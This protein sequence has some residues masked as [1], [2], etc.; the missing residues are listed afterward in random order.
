MGRTGRL[1]CTLLKR[2]VAVRR[3]GVFTSKA[4]NLGDFFLSLHPRPTNPSRQAHCARRERWGIVVWFLDQS[5]PLTIA[6]AKADRER[7]CTF[8]PKLSNAL[9]KSRLSECGQAILLVDTSFCTVCPAAS[10]R[11]LSLFNFVGGSHGQTDALSRL[12]PVIC[13]SVSSDIPHCTLP[14]LHSTRAHIGAAIIL[15]QSLRWQHCRQASWG[16]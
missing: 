4:S 15:V 8:L 9:Q 13:K 6:K 10:S 5:R 1:D 11:R 2:V 3:T 12:R 16:L 14:H 7:C